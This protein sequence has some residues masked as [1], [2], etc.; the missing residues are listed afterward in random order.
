MRWRSIHEGVQ[1]AKSRTDYVQVL[2]ERWQWRRRGDKQ[3]HEAW[4][5]HDRD[6]VM[7]QGN[8]AEYRL[9]EAVATVGADVVQWVMERRERDSKPRTA[10]EILLRRNEMLAEWAKRVD[11]N[12]KIAPVVDILRESNSLLDDIPFVRGT[13]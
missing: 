9:A 5:E 12:S 4:I 2:R 10:T 1:P 8:P 6:L 3:L 7:L 13:R 11:P